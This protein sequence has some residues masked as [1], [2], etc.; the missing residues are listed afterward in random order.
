M[1][2]QEPTIAIFSTFGGIPYEFF[3]LTAS[4]TMLRLPYAKTYYY[5][6]TRA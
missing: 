6:D 4:F 5:V 3:T 2:T 1:Y